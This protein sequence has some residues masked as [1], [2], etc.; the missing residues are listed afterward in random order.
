MELNVEPNVEVE[1]RHSP[2]LDPRAELLFLILSRRLF[3]FFFLSDIYN[4]LDSI[5]ICN[6]LIQCSRA[7]LSHPIPSP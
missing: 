5:L 3:F 4:S 2:A 7:G 1:G 6:M